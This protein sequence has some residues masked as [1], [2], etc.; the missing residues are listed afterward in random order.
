MGKGN[1]ARCHLMRLWLE[2]KSGFAIGI[3]IVIVSRFEKD[4]NNKFLF[5]DESGK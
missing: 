4:S 1:V 5:L 3:W 2:R